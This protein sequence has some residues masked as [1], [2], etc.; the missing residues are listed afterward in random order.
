MKKPCF[1]FV[2]FFLIPSFFFIYKRKIRYREVR[3]TILAF[4]I[5]P[6]ASIDEYRQKSKRSHMDH[7]VMF[8]EK[9]LSFYKK[10]KKEKKSEE[11]PY[12]KIKKNRI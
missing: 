5:S 2:R 3:Q 4:T 10:K 7:A 6:S 8:A 9:L 12:F 1:R 11:K